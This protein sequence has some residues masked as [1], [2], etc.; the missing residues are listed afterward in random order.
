MY[1]NYMYIWY[2]AIWHASNNFDRSRA[3]KRISENFSNAN[4]T[5][6]PQYCLPDPR[7][8]LCNPIPLNTVVIQC[9]LPSRQ[10]LHF[11]CFGLVHKWAYAGNNGIFKQ[12][13]IE[14]LFVAWLSPRK[15]FMRIVLTQ[16]F[17]IYSG[18]NQNQHKENE[19]V[20]LYVLPC[21]HD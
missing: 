8:P 2:H 18:H 15:I 17:S 9:R 11:Y 19:T 16:N 10:L 5:F 21:D 13:S 6:N 7:G 1:V 20:N 12:F 4:K 14:K 3:S